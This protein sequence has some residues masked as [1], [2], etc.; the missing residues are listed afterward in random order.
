[1]AIFA[2]IKHFRHQLE[3]RDFKIS[4]DHKPLI[5]AFQQKFDK[6]SPRQL[7][8]LDFISQI[9]TN[10][11]YIKGID[12]IVADA[13]SRIHTI[14]MPTIISSQQLHDS[15]Q[16]DKELENLVQNS[17]SLNLQHL[18]I[19]NYSI[20]CDVTNG[21]VRPYIPASLRRT[22][23]DTVYSLSHPSGRITARTLKGK[24]VWPG[25]KKDALKWARE[26]LDCQ[27]AK[28]QRHN[29]LSPQGIEVP[30]SRFNHIHFDL[31]HLPPID[32]FRYCLTVIDRFT[33]RPV[34]V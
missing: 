23:S 7:R 32:G 18:L 24:Y 27:R 29:R 21:T 15:Q 2:A 16:D 11:V 25:I 31:I 30:D 10:I 34:A 22:A 4:T 9:S 26:Y 33:R 1:M 12:N 17:T 19:E 8:Q 28:V 14:D 13:L 6:A 5:H 20:Y 3:C